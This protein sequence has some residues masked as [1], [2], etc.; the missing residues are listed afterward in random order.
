MFP[1]ETA[2]WAYSQEQCKEHQRNNMLF[3]GADGHAQFPRFK[4]FLS[5]HQGVVTRT[6]WHYDDVNHTQGA[7]TELNK[8][9]ISY[10]SNPKPTRLI[11][12]ILRIA[13][14]KNAIAMDFFSGSATTAHAVMQLNAEDGGHRKFIMVQLPERCEEKSEAYKAGYKT[15]CDIGEERIRRAGKKIKDESPM[16]T[17]DL[18]VGFR[19]FRVDDSNMKDV[20]YRPDDLGQIDIEDMIDNIKSD[21]T[22]EDLLFQTMLS[23]GVFPSSKIEEI[24]VAGK[25]VFDVADGFLLACFDSDVNDIVVTEIA[26]RKPSYAVFRDSGFADDAVS[27]NFDQI[28]REYSPNTER[29]VL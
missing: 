1:K 20:Y 22:P 24:T 10:F 9:G 18:D 2:V 25:K 29:K 5:D 3:W 8:L 27:V 14:D 15:I 7:T 13:T 16:T 21:R 11:E 17:Q 26:K 23:L 4:K 6:L 12:K 19:V 28:F